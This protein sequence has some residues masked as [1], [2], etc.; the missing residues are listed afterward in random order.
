MILSIDRICQRYGRLPTELMQS[1]TSFDFVVCDTAIKWEVEQQNRAE[2]R[3]PQ[4]KT[5]SRQELEDI[6]T[7]FRQ[8]QEQ[9]ND[10]EKS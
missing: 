9:S 1:G 8:R 5:Y 10:S 4:N 6:M 7:K 3:A 2:G